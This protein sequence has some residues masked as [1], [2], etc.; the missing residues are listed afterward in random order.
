MDAKARPLADA[1]LIPRGLTRSYAA[2]TAQW[3]ETAPPVVRLLGLDLT[4]AGPSAVARWLAARPAGSPFGYVVTPNADHF[5]RLSRRPDLVPLYRE[6]LLRLLD[7]RVVGRAAKVSGLRAPRVATGSDLAAA[8]LRQ[9]DPQERVTIIGLRPDRVPMLMARTGIAAPAHHYPPMGFEHDQAA[10]RE[11]VRFVIDHP[12][13]F[14]F[15]AVGSPRQE[16]LAGAIQ[17]TGRAVGT[18]LCIGAGLEFLAGAARRAPHWMQ[19]AGLEWLH[20]LAG[21]PRR[22]ARRYLCDDPAVFALLLRERFS[23]RSAAVPEPPA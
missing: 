19:L 16:M 6:A 14:V 3:S 23:P 15:I 7:S 13:R 17:R 5:V 8:I 11:A 21:D 22:L 10:L 9:L 12:T 4:D 18:G 20:R 1:G 2:P